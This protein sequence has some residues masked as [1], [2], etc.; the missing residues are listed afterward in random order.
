MAL[1]C[2]RVLH[3][4]MLPVLA[5]KEIGAPTSHA[6]KPKATIVFNIMEQ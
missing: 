5:N 1:S 4:P 6:D 3:D 2:W